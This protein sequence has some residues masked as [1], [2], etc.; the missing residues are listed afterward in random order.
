MVPEVAKTRHKANPVTKILALK[1]NEDE[2]A[3]WVSTHEELSGH[4]QYYVWTHKD[5]L[6]AEKASEFGTTGKSFLICL[7]C[8]LVLCPVSNLHQLYLLREGQPT[9]FLCY[10]RSG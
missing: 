6:Y 5:A 1:D 8:Y 9:T 7:A 3:E 2:L 10:S 4:P